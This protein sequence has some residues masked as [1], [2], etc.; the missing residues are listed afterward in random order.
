M[1]NSPGVSS[2]ISYFLPSMFM[3]VPWKGKTRIKVK[4][5][6]GPEGPG[7]DLTRDVPRMPWPRPGDGKFGTGG[8]GPTPGDPLPGGCLAL[9]KRLLGLGG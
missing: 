1:P 8:G 6:A 3:K 4:L 2:R 5:S 9:L 7:G